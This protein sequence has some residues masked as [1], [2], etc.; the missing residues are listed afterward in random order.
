[1]QTV[2]ALTARL[3][4]V[5]HKLCMENFFSSPELSDNLHTMKINCYGTVGPNKKGSQRILDRK[6]N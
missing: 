1:M 4:N 3:E 5:G 2:N 6:F